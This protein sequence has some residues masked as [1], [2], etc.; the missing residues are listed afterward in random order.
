MP[1]TNYSRNLGKGSA[2][3]DH[4]R[5]NMGHTSNKQIALHSRSPDK[6]YSAPVRCSPNKHSSSLRRHNNQQFSGQ[7]HH[8]IQSKKISTPSIQHSFVASTAEFRSNHSTL[9]PETPKD[10]S[11]LYRDVSNESSKNSLKKQSAPL[12]FPETI[13]HESYNR[14]TD[15]HAANR[16]NYRTQDHTPFNTSRASKGS[17]STGESNTRTSQMQNK[18]VLQINDNSYTII[19]QIGKG[20]SSVVYFALD[21]KNQKRAIKKVDLSQIDEQQAEDFKNEISYLERLKGNDRIIEIFGWEQKIC[22]DG[23]FLY[24]VMECGDRDLGTLLKELS[25]PNNSSLKQ[26]NGTSVSKR[27]GLTDNKVKFYWEEMLEAV[28]VIHGEG[29]VHRDLKPGNFVIVGGR[30]KLIDFGIGK[31]R[32]YVSFKTINILEFILQGIKMIYK[33]GDT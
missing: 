12:K 18:Q 3:K 4:P 31:K 21:D 9:Y 15:V 29:I 25:S 10:Q 28:Q 23:K 16:V 7:D 14:S 32:N 1:V 27:R 5:R 20:G 6:K 17:Q 22:D 19:N 2:V 11:S 33:R 24:L 8:H 13:Y 30:I 26:T